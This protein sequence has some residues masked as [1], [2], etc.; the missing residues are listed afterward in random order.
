MSV[1]GTY[2]YIHCFCFVFVILGWLINW[3]VWGCC[4]FSKFIGQHLKSNISWFP[5]IQWLKP[6][7]PVQG[8]WLHSWSGNW[9]HRPQPKIEDPQHNKTWCCQINKYIFFNQIFHIKTCDS[10][11]LFPVPKNLQSWAGLVNYK[12]EGN[13]GAPQVCKQQVR[14]ATYPIS[15]QALRPRYAASLSPCLHHQPQLKPFYTV[16]CIKGQSSR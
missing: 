2:R 3:L 11:L 14:G 9:F 4:F 8:S 6:V 15:S 7:L 10:Y 5:G 16:E 12:H 1:S 13:Q